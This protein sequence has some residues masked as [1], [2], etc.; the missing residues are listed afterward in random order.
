MAGVSQAVVSY[1]LNDNQTVSISPVTRQRVLDVI[2]ELDYVPN[3]AARSLRSQR[4]ATIAAII[5]D[6]ANPYYPTFVRGIQDVARAQGFDVLTYN[7]DGKRDLEHHA[8]D[9]AR[10]GRVDGLILT[11]FHLTVDDLLPI[12]GEGTPIT[13]LSEMRVDGDAAAHLP[14][15]SVSV[16]GELAAREVV[17]YLIDRGH[18]H[19]G[20]IAGQSSTP[21]RE[22]RVLGYRRALAEHHLPL[23]ELL[24]RGG[25]FSEE[26]GYD[27]MRELIALDPRPTAVFAANDLMAMGA[28]LAAREAGL[29]VPDDIAL[30]GFDDIPAARLVHPALTTIDQQANLSGRRAAELLLSRLTGAFMG[31]HRAEHLGFRLVVRESA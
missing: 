18:T 28:L 25:D 21:P 2:A 3:T 23:E 31:P 9:A 1:V 27:A 6:I 11:P 15:D 14:L 13:L 7:T 12:L 8:L 29:S 22:T 24:I 5:P 19:I 4:T 17:N 16:S 10:R 26:G 30:A 20:M